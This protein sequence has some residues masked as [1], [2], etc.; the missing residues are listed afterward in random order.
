MNLFTLDTE[1]VQRFAEAKT[2]LTSAVR[3]HGKETREFYINFGR[4]VN[5][6]LSRRAFQVRAAPTECARARDIHV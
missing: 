1:C 2:S 3:A 4:V 6:V 5:T